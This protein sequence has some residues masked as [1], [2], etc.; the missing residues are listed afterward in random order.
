MGVRVPPFAP[1]TARFF[2]NIYDDLGQYLVIFSLEESGCLFPCLESCRAAS[3]KTF[4]TLG[5]AEW[6]SNPHNLPA[7]PACSAIGRR[8]DSSG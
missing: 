5:P 6:L 8:A 4:R 1:T 3:A 7:N 2:W